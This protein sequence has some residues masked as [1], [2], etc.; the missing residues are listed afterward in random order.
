MSR[1]TRVLATLT[2]ALA[3]AAPVA[4]QEEVETTTISAIER[5]EAEATVYL[6]GA[7]LEQLDD[8]EYLFS[9]GTGVITIDVDADAGEG[10]LPLFELIGVEGT[11][12]SDEIDVS[13]WALLPIVTPAV[14]VPEEQVIEAFWGWIVAYGSQAPAPTE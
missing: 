3:I 10:E 13:R 12:A 6:E 8:E 2:V 4:A 14:I 11:V 5:G 9:D 7:A 1:I